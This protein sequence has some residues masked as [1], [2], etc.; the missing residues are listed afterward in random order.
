MRCLL[1]ALCALFAPLALA[2]EPPLPA[3]AVARLGTTKYR[4]PAWGLCVSP[5]GKRAALRVG[6][7][8]D[9]MNL[10][11]GEVVARLRDDKLAREPI[12]REAPKLSYAFA[13]GGKE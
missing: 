1:T 6:D 7:G 8:I 2:A 11:T 13:T 12:G 4:T 3:G 9:V 10:D 5:D